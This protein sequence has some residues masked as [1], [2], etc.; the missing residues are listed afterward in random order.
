MPRCRVLRRYEG[1]RKQHNSGSTVRCPRVT[2]CNHHEASKPLPVPPLSAHPSPPR[3]AGRSRHR[4]LPAPGTKSPAWLGPESRQEE[5]TPT[6]TR[7]QEYEHRF[8]LSEAHTCWAVK[9]RPYIAI[10]LICTVLEIPNRSLNPRRSHA[11]AANR[12]HRS[13]A[14]DI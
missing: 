3:A 1:N 10:V 2:G 8:G 7:R 12:Q 9:L 4:S 6:E 13:G 11:S 14:A 5:R